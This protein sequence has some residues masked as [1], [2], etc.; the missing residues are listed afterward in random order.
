MKADQ[1][2]I[3]IINKG[4]RL[5]GDFDFKG[6]LIIAGTVKG[7]LRADTVITEEGSCVTAQIT[8][9]YATIAGSFEGHI[10]TT[11]SLTLSKTSCVDAA[12]ECGTLIIEEGCL[13]NGRI[14]KC[15]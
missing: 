14:T 15:A 3:S 4:C 13:F 5:E 10:S 9:A 1:K 2:N 12:L 7:T 6:Y 8:A 11:G